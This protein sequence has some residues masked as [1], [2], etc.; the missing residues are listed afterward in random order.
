MA[1]QNASLGFLAADFLPCIFPH[2]VM[3]TTNDIKQQL[4]EDII[5]ICNN[6]D[7]QIPDE[8]IIELCQV[9]A[10]WDTELAD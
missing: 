9:V 6:F 10:D 2:P 1:P 5:T 7:T 4:Q 8:L 3:Q